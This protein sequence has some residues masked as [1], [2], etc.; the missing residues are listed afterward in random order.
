MVNKIVDECEDQAAHLVWLKS[1]W[2][3]RKPPCS[4]TS[5]LNHVSPTHH[6]EHSTYHT[7]KS[8]HRIPIRHTKGLLPP[9]PKHLG[10]SHE[11]RRNTS[12]ESAEPE[13]SKKQTAECVRRGHECQRETPQGDH[14]AGELS[15]G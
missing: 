6:L 5:K 10:N 7:G 15:N 13:P 14:A 9:P 4:Q 3:L 12:L 8:I 11:T 2:Q 1:Q